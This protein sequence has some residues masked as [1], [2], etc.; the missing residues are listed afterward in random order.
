MK[1]NKE[2]RNNHISFATTDSTKQTID[3]IAEEREW[4]TSQ[5]CHYILDKYCREHIK[6][7]EDNE[8]DC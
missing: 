1:K 6:N 5:V 3:K 4:T 2:K 7:T 8:V